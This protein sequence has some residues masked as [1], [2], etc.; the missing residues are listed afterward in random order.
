MTAG[1]G[2]VIITVVVYNLDQRSLNG[3]SETEGFRVDC[4]YW[5]RGKNDS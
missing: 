3:N 4:M 5:N 1:D 2:H